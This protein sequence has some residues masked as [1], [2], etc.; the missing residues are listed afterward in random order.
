MAKVFKT[1]K[2]KAQATPLVGVI[3]DSLKSEN[4]RQNAPSIQAVIDNMTPPMNKL[5]N[6][7]FQ[8]NQR[9]Q[10]SYV[11]NKDELKLTVDCWIM[12]SSSWE[13]TILTPLKDGVRI[14][15]ITLDEGGVSY[16]NSF[17][18]IL[19]NEPEGDKTI[20]INVTNLTGHAKFGVLNKK[21]SGVIL[22]KKELV[23]GINIF[24]F[25][26]NEEKNLI[27]RYFIDKNT[28]ISI[29]YTNLFEG[30]IAYHHVK[31]DKT[32]A[33]LRCQS[34]LAPINSNKESYSQ[35]LKFI[36]GGLY[37]YVYLPTM[38]GTPICIHNN[39]QVFDDE[40]TWKDTTVSG[41]NGDGNGLYRIELDIKENMIVHDD[42]NYIV[43]GLQFLSCE[44]L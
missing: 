27:I 11:Q 15:S 6:G 31:E 19:E 25:N 43:R 17:S 1:L 33:L 4:P 24:H 41:V 21:D 23:K 40:P 29:E 9:G 14:Q 20:V 3:L 5:K 13:K 38:K 30:D 8:I 34:K 32:I 7:D 12:A 18:Q 10:S 2:K 35:A 44:S 26:V 22:D 39:L 36:G 42:G 16:S 37:V 28:D